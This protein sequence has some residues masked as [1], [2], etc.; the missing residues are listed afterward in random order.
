MLKFSV[1]PFCC[2]VSP[3]LAGLP[4]TQCPIVIDRGEVVVSMAP[5]YPTPRASTRYC[6]TRDRFVD[7]RYE[8][9]TASISV[10]LLQAPRYPWT[11]S[12][13]FLGQATLKMTGVGAAK[14][15]VSIDPVL[16]GARLECN[17]TGK[18]LKGDATG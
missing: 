17:E 1:L 7:L 2:L 10:T 11:F 16:S 13:H 3:A 18:S 9:F 4:V 8:A 15:A 12:E 14:G 5:I 6:V